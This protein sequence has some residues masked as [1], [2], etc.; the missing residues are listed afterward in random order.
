M[1]V[2]WVVIW[3]VN[4]GWRTVSL[5]RHTPAR[6]S[7]SLIY[8]ILYK[9]TANTDCN[10]YFIQD[11]TLMLIDFILTAIYLAVLRH[12]SEELPERIQDCGLRLRI[13]LLLKCVC[14]NFNKSVFSIRNSWFDRKSHDVVIKWKH[15]PRYWPFVRGKSP[16]TGEFA[17]QRPVTQSF[18]VF[19][20]LR[21]NKR[22]SKQSWGW[23]F[24]TP[25]RSLWRHCNG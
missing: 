5:Y 10:W 24:E 20:D 19:F 11:F 21:L 7:H 18:D 4:G 16:V 13:Y 25:S 8:I 23:W 2:H 22:L 12:N 15:F 9:L 6:V 14:W 3:I 1:H 17:S